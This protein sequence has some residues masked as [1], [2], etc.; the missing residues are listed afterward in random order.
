MTTKGPNHVGTTGPV[1]PTR[2]VWCETH[3]AFSARDCLGPGCVVNDKA[4][5][6]ELE[7]GGA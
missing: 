5:L 3:K 1:D 4:A 2:F 6:P 7:E